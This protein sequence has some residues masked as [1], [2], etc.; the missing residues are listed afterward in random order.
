MPPTRAYDATSSFANWETVST[1]AIYHKVATAESLIR[2]PQNSFD[3][4][5][6]ADAVHATEIN[7]TF[8]QKT[9]R[10]WRVRF[11]DLMANFIGRNRTGQF[12]RRAAEN[13]NDRN[14]ERSGDMHRTRVIGQKHATK[15]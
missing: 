3:N 14:A 10:A 13:D 11:Q 2:H 5:F 6:D 4:A 15:F 1:P 9:W 8:A 7:R 12:R